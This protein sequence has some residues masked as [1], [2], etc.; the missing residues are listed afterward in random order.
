MAATAAATVLLLG[1]CSSNLQPGNAAVV[2]GAAI[3]QSE[4]DD[5][6]SAGC[7]YEAAMGKTDRETYPLLSLASLRTNFLNVLIRNHLARQAADE[8]GGLHVSQNQVSS[9]AAGNTIPPTLDDQERSRV[10]DFFHTSAETDLLVALIGAHLKDDTVTDA[11]HVQQ[12]D[13]DAGQKYLDAYTK[14][15]D[16]K[17]NPRFGTW[18]GTTVKG[19]SGSL[20]Q[21]AST[22]PTPAAI[23]GQPAPNPAETL[24]PD[25]V[26][27]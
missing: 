11:S 25:Q 6:V 19:G 17:V 7:A 13:L 22:P 3:P 16:V 15:A 8:I 21:L 4:V 26:C 10:E 18:T 24:P 14:K 12:A 2:N 20:S 27:G 9:L 5:L 1:A 23:P